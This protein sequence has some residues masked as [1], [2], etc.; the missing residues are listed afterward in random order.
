M[1]IIRSIAYALPERE[2]SNSDL[3][4]EYPGWNMAKVV[5]RAGVRSRR[6][7]EADETAFDLS[8]RAC[9]KL[10][11]HGGVDMSAID[12]ILYCTQ[13]PDHVM[14]GNAHLLHHHLGLGDDVLAFDYTLACSGYVYGL[15]LADSLVRAGLGSEV[16]LVTAETYSKRIHPGD[17]STRVLFGD[18]A[19]VTHLSGGE[20]GGR[21]VAARLCSQG[22]VFERAFIPAGGARRPRTEATRREAADRSGNVRTEETIHMDGV[23]V[24][25]FVNS[26]I[27]GHI[28]SFL[29]ERSLNMEDVDLCVFHQASK[30]TH[31]SLVKALGVEPEKLYTHLEDVGNLVSA[32]IPVALRAA[33]DEGAIRPG[34]LVLLSGFGAG[35]SYGSVLVEF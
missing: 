18:G 6:V 33:L 35:A 15:A 31:D 22:R 5:E 11:D 28:A 26:A 16:L 34:D 23:G 13:T 7:A 20:G 30:V 2:L 17:R 14:P 8:V 29:A 27:P 4:S 24:W 3:E 32:S 12:A 1:T 10:A 19:A 25:S 9:E 21:I